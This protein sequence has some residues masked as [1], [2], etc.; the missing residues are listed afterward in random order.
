[1]RP[2]GGGSKNPGAEK[3]RPESPAVPE[4]AA[5]ARRTKRVFFSWT[6]C[7]ALIALVVFSAFRVTTDHGVWDYR[8]WFCLAA[9][10]VWA[11]NMSAM[12]LSEAGVKV[13]WGFGLRHRE[14]AWEDIRKVT[15]SRFFGWPALHAGCRDWR[16]EKLGG[17]SLPREFRRAEAAFRERGIRVERVATRSTVTWQ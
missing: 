14:L 15:V 2:E 1:M 10:P 8:A 4:A 17:V 6:E 11:W 7:A 3:E 5:E 12:T 13:V 16:S 9:W